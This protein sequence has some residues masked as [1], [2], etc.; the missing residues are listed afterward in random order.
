M[1]T[2]GHMQVKLINRENKFNRRKIPTYESADFSSINIFSIL[3]YV[4]IQKNHTI[5]HLYS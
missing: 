1:M 2:L 3:S 5:N 4:F